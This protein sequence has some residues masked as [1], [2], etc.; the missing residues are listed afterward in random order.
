MFVFVCFSLQPGIESYRDYMYA[1]DCIFILMVVV[2]VVVVF[3]SV[4]SI[5]FKFYKYF[6]L[7]FFLLCT[8]S[9]LFSHG[10]SSPYFFLTVFHSLLEFRF[11]FSLF[12]KINSWHSR[13]L[14]HLI[15]ICVERGIKI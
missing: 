7:L 8:L 10:F 4:L 6:V 15:V 2:I 14:T 11:F 9:S 3:F 13:I 12:Y 1:C 5:S